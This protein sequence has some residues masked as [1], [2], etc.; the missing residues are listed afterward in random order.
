[1]NGTQTTL[2]RTDR[3][4]QLVDDARGPLT[5]QMTKAHHS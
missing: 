2:T 1:M 4:I 5:K 3:S